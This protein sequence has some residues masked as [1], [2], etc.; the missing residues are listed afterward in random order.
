MLVLNVLKCFFAS[1]IKYC[2]LYCKFLHCLIP[3]NFCSIINKFYS[4]IKIFLCCFGCLNF[5][6]C[7]RIVKFDFLLCLILWIRSICSLVIWLCCRWWCLSWCTSAW[8]CFYSFFVNTAFFLSSG[9]SSLGLPLLSPFL[10]SSSCI[11]RYRG[12]CAKSK[13]FFQYLLMTWLYHQEISI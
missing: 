6:W 1:I 13:I 7:W 8:R 5:S 10:E 12:K 9:T 4:I 3:F 11:K 2:L